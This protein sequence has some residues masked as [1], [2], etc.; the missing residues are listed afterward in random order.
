MALADVRHEVVHLLALTH[1][2]QREARV[3]RVTGT[4]EA[5]VMAAGE[6]NFLGRQEAMLKARLDEID[7]RARKPRTLFSGLR[8]VWFDL[9]LNLESW[10]VHG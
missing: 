6:L 7:E 10:I 8:Q 9:M 5:K 4:D 1:E 3:A 2:A